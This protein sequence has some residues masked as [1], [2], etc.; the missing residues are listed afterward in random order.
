MFLTKL[1]TEPSPFLDLKKNQKT[2]SRAT[3]VN[4]ILYNIPSYPPQP[5]YFIEISMV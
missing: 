2:H 4:F 1:M 3:K 5:Q